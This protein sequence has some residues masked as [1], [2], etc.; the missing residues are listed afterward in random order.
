MFH[1]LFTSKHIATVVQ[2][3]VALAC[4]ACECSRPVFELS[5]IVNMYQMTELYFT[6]T[7][8]VCVMVECTVQGDI[9][10][11]TKKY[12]EVV[13]RHDWKWS[14]RSVLLLLILHFALEI[15]VVLK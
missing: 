10:R 4:G 7:A 8:M 13:G 1:F 5:I 2:V 12:L 11:V 6:H 9:V 3:A 15:Y 14:V